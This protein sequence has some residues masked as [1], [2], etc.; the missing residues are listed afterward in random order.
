M[1]MDRRNFLK[2]V[3][4]G[5]A[6]VATCAAVSPEAEAFPARDPLPIS[7]D[8]LGMLYD[9]TLCVG[10]KACVKACKVANGM[11]EDIPDAL[12]RLQKAVDANPNAHLD[13]KSDKDEDDENEKTHVSLANRALPLI[14]LLKAAQADNKHVMWE[15]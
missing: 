6:A 12:Q 15:S 11:P 3:A 2:G 14:E 1:N 8:A 13:P 4:A 10:C 9:S 5:G 7:P